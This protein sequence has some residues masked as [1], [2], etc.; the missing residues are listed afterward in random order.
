MLWT[1]HFSLT[2]G[3]W[4]IVFFYNTL[5]WLFIYLFIFL[6]FHLPTTININIA[7]PYSFVF[8]LFWLFLSPSSYYKFAILSLTLYIFYNIK[9]L[10][11]LSHVFLFFLFGFFFLVSLLYVDEFPCSLELYYY[12]PP[13]SLSPFFVWIFYFMFY[14]FTLG[15]WICVSFR[16]LL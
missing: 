3:W 7:L 15:W 12:S 6:P 5:S 13:L 16:T 11:S 1:Y 10:F 8:F 14:I 9:R 2:L 4:I